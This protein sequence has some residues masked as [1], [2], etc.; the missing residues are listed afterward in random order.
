LVLEAFRVHCDC[1]QPCHTFLSLCSIAVRSLFFFVNVAATTEIY[2]L[3][4]HDALPISLLVGPEVSLGGYSTSR[5]LPPIRGE[6]SARPNPGRSHAY[7]VAA[8]SPCGG[9]RPRAG[10]RASR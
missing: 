1:V 7:G 4:L 9:R 10:P 6:S 8:S 5:G 3:S 2:T